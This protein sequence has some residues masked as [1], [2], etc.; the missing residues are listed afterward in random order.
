MMADMKL[1]TL[2]ETRLAPAIGQLRAAR[3]HLGGGKSG[4]V[5]AYSADFD[6]DPWH[7]MFYFPTDTLKISL[8][9]STGELLWTRDLGK[10]VVPGMWFVPVFPFDL[11]GDG[12]D[13]LYFVNNINALHPL[14]LNGQRL[15]RLDARTGKTTGQWPW[16]AHAGQ[17]V[18]S[19]A[20]RNF[21]FGGY[22]H[23]APVLVA[24]QGT[25]GPMFFQAYDADMKP[26][27]ENAIAEDA[28]GPRGSHQCP[29]VDLNQD[30]VDEVLW[31]ERCISLADGREL[32]C[33]DRDGYRG[34]SDIIQPV[35]NA[36]RQKWFLYTCRES[37][38]ATS[39]RVVL[40]D[41]RGQ[42]VWGAVEKG[43]MDLGW[44][45]R[46]GPDRQHVAMAIKIGAKTCGPDGRHHQERV[47]FAWDLWTGEPVQLP[48][49]IYLTVPVDLNGD[50]Y[51]ELVRGGPSADGEV[52]DRA[53]RTLGN[54]G[55][56]VALASKLVA[57]PGEQMLSYHEDGHIKL[58]AD[59]NAADAPDALG[60]LWPAVLPAHAA[61]RR[62]GFAPGDGSGRVGTRR[63][64]ARE[65]AW[66]APARP[67]ARP[68]DIFAFRHV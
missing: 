20:Y 52:L 12:V 31:G 49:S 55:G 59:R 68:R 14:S 44:V 7:E 35:W 63:G 24:A 15:E 42:R 19:H 8:L 57:H 22:V 66:A 58:W 65:S 4:F 17:Q 36:E 48:L 13:E 30:G 23:G 18:I 56:S 2:W 5:V 51:H 27:W 29:V 50:G 54:I 53:G 21:I 37:D 46:I 28:P 16:A 40:F 62:H 10:G 34:H 64:A 47:E 43:H 33:A 3:V 6:V 32:F 39:P 25:Y 61:F 11:D 26:R 41:N 45:A 9:S 60:R 38:G 1:E 67:R